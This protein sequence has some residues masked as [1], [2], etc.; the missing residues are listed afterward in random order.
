MQAE[1]LLQQRQRL[2]SDERVRKLIGKQAYE[3]Y[4]ERGG[5]YG[6]DQ[7]DWARAEADVISLLQELIERESKLQGPKKTEARGPAVSRAPQR[8]SKTTPPVALAKKKSVATPKPSRKVIPK[9][10]SSIA[11]LATN[12]PRPTN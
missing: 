4:L 11:P 6:K 3:F 12:S 9:K 10:K 8:S 5:G 1:W 7:E 2:L